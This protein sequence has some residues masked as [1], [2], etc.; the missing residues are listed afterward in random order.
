MFIDSRLV[1][2]G[3][4]RAWGWGSVPFK[5]IIVALGMSLA[6]VGSNAKTIYR[7]IP[8]EALTE[9]RIAQQ[10][11]SKRGEWLAYLARS[12]SL[13]RADKAAL[14]T[15]SKDQTVASEQHEARSSGDS[16]PLGRPSSWYASADAR[17]V[18]DNIVSFQ[19]PAG[20]WGKNQDRIGPLRQV[21]QSYVSRENSSPGSA[22]GKGLVDD[23]WAYVGTIDNGATTT[24]L[25]FLAKVQAQRPGADGQH[26]RSAILK[27]LRYLLLAE[28]PSGGWPQVYPLQG[29]YHDALTFNDNAVVHVTNLLAKAGKREGEFAFIPQ[30]LAIDAS[31]AAARAVAMILK[32]QVIIGGKRAIWGQQHD[33]LTLAP[34]GARNFEPA[35]LSSDES[36]ELLLFLISQPDPSPTVIAS[37]RDGVAWLE[38]HAV[39]G[40]E[41]TTDRSGPEGR[42]LIKNAS[43]A[44]IWA[45]FYDI[46]TGLPIFGDRDRSIKD[47]VN[48]VSLERR[49]GYKW[50]GTYPRKAIDAY[51]RWNQK[52]ETSPFRQQ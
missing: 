47:D 14:V 13:M 40:V 21:G 22:S 52:V 46:Q 43:A 51:R 5:M 18:A 41:W 19:T 34:V 50:F 24:E 25:R 20:G 39:Q 15:E 48:E 49:N 9:A 36:A 45:R 4:A 30:A 31:T 8:A 29:G 6:F 10:P 23:G 27:G 42:R 37:V 38:A 12:R 11:E 44:P 16:M 17:H 2:A 33:P 28:L 35:A 3:N 7:M 32:T 26:Y 1:L